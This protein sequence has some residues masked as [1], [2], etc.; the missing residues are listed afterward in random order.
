MQT[1]KITRKV[2]YA[3]IQLNRGKVNAMNTQFLEELR[4]TVQT[5]QADDTVRGVIITGQP[6]FFSAGL[7]LIELYDY[8]HAQMEEFSISFGHMYM[9]LARFPKP[10]I[11]AIT[12]HSPAGGCVIAQTCDYRVM[13]EGEK[14]TIGLNEILVNVGLSEDLIRGYAFWLGEGLANRYL[15]QGKLMTGQEALAVGFVDEVCPMDQVLERAEAQMQQYL[16]ATTQIFQAIK[17]KSRK[18]WL[19]EM[20]KNG[21]AELEEGSKIWWNPKVRAKMKVF[22]DRLAKR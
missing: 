13:T 22:V 18:D 9:E 4:S 10:L 11:A 20:G 2:D 16:K 5:F 14:Y 17:S 19:S 8:D 7:D 6:H 12:G 15:L 21:A 3:I 1:L